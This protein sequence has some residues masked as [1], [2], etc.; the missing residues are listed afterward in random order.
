MESITSVLVVEA[1]FL[2]VQWAL[3]LGYTTAVDKLK[4]HDV[5]VETRSVILP[6]LCAHD[7][8]GREAN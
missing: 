6:S 7:N 5:C 8:N 3:I 2:F 4:Y 1:K